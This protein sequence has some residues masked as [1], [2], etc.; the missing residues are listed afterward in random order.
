MYREVLVRKRFI[1]FAYQ[2]P[3]VEI[4]SNAKP[5]EKTLELSI[6]LLKR[7]SE[8]ANVKNEET[9]NEINRKTH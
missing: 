4:S 5:G 9:R 6:S 2:G 1:S 7:F 8:F 3:V